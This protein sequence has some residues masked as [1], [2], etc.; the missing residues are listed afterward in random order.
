MLVNMIKACNKLCLLCEVKTWIQ[1]K[2]P[3]QIDTTIAE[4]SQEEVTALTHHKPQ[5]CALCDHL[6]HHGQSISKNSVWEHLKKR[7]YAKQL[8]WVNS[9]ETDRNAM[10]KNKQNRKQT[11]MLLLGRASARK[12]S[13]TRSKKV[14]SH[15][16]CHTFIIY[17]ID[18]VKAPE[19]CLKFYQTFRYAVVHLETFQ[20][21]V[22]PESLDAMERSCT[23]DQKSHRTR[24]QISVH[25]V[26]DCLTQINNKRGSIASGIVLLSCYKS[27]TERSLKKNH[28]SLK[29]KVRK[30]IQARRSCEVNKETLTSPSSWSSTK[31]HSASM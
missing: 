5:V 21:S 29:K 16:S 22:S 4:L 19:I 14:G 12:Q 3:V 27:L 20:R 28:V 13:G 15:S 7:N 31:W 26:T 30:L 18:L 6:N 17:E 25:R 24:Q 11:S 1:N 10:R 2:M 23:R 8:D 9:L